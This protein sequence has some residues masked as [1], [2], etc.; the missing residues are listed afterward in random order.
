MIIVVLLGVCFVV[1]GRG[2]TGM[3]EGILVD[4]RNR[5]SLSRLQLILWTMLVLST[6]L[7]IAMFNI[8]KDP[9][10]NPLDIGVPPQVWGLLGISTTSF[11]TAATIKSQKKNLNVTK[12]ATE[13]TTEALRKVGDDPGKLAD[14]QG[15]LVAYEKPGDAS[16]SDLFKGDEVISA[17]YLD[18]GKVQ[19]FF[20]TLIVIFAYA[21]EV[22]ALL[23]QAQTV[24]YLP[25]LTAE[26]MS[27]DPA[28]RS[29]HNVRTI[30]PCP[31]A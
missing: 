16:V 1:I 23:L 26:F 17:A 19:V 21:S 29:S 27:I 30:Q 10:S 18:L 6:F 24:S 3:W 20:F 31:A 4:A 13:K 9:T 7:T 2:T 11:V 22:G 12:E 25:G 5:M 15:A 8:R 14:P 28:I